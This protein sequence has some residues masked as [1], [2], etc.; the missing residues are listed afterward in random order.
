MAMRSFMTVRR[1]PAVIVHTVGREVNDVTVLHA[2]LL[3]V[4]LTMAATFQAG[5]QMARAAADWPLE[6]AL[7]RSLSSSQ[8]F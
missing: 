3:A 7:P 2:T 1:A 5:N 6:R 4:R 8:T